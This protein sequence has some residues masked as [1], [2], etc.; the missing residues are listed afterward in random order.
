MNMSNF[1][2]EILKGCAWI[3]IFLC[4]MTLVYKSN[5]DKEFDEINKNVSKE[6]VKSEEYSAIVYIYYSDEEI[7]TFENVK[8]VKRVDSETISFEKEDDEIEILHG[9]KY[10][11]VYLKE[12]ITQV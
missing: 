4:F 12:K 9:F 6:K 7:E 2:V 11:I 8:N 3:V 1:L 10:E 5:L